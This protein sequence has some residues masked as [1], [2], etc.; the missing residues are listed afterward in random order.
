M[1]CKRP[2]RYVNSW[3]P[4][5]GSLAELCNCVP[6][7]TTALRSCL[8]HADSWQLRQLL[9]AQAFYV[10]RTGRP[11]PVLV[12]IPKDEQQTMVVPH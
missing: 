6:V 7:R 10:A 8:G 11:G 2:L 3:N 12:D 4:A 5:C 1:G 9:C